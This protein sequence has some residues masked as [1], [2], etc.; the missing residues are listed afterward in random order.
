[1]GQITITAPLV[2]PSSDDMILSSVQVACSISFKVVS[3]IIWMTFGLMA[4]TGLLNSGL[5]I[6]FY[7]SEFKILLS[8]EKIKFN[9]SKN[10]LGI[11]KISKG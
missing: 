1:M 2:M 8:F 11:T 4:R 3:N 7:T 6:T 10:L 5:L 9:T